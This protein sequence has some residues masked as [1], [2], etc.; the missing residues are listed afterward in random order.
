VTDDFAVASRYLRGELPDDERAAFEERIVADDA[1]HTLVAAAEDELLDEYAAGTL[2]GPA[3]ARLA[4]RLAADPALRA[5]LALAE[6]LFRRAAREPDVAPAPARRR[7]WWFAAPMVLA[8]AAVLVLVLAGGDG[9]AR[10]P[11]VVTVALAA[12]TR[13]STVAEVRLPDRP[14]TVRLELDVAAAPDLAVTLVGPRGPVAITIAPPAPA[15]G[16]AVVEVAAGAHAPGL[17]DLTV[18]AAGA[19]VVY[20]V[21][22]RAAAR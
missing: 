17:Y 6:G 1:V 2:R 20:Q 14:A 16:G 3:R 21:R 7:W 8:A 22:V 13:S 11:G 9:P 12:P 19:T 10:P 4:A 18:T 5:R 15:P